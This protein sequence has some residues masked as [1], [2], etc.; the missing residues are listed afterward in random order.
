[1]C[2]KI[3]CSKKEEVIILLLVVAAIKLRKTADILAILLSFACRI[4]F[5]QST[6]IAQ[7]LSS[8]QDFV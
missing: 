2:G 6:A 3:S 5:S 4:Y 8:R 1:M 7:E